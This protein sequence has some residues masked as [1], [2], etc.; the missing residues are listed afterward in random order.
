MRFS[1]GFAVLCAA[2]LLGCSP[3]PPPAPTAPPYN[4]SLSMKQLMEWVIDAAADEV[5]E[6]VAIIIT[7]KGENHKAPKTDEEWAKVRAGA[8]TLV[9]SGNLLMMQ[10]RTR[11]ELWAAGAKRLSDAAMVALQAT[12]KKDVEALFDSGA[13]IYNACSACHAANR[14]GEDAPAA[15]AAKTLPDAAPAKSAK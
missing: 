15:P 9:E 1:V 8:A 3:A 10:G 13:T 7:E 4:T 12:E 11:G 5:W 14:V 2:M 6:S